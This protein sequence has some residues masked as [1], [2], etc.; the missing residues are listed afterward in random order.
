MS[1][2]YCPNLGIWLVNKLFGMW[3]C[4][5][6]GM[7]DQAGSD[8]SDYACANPTYGGSRLLGLIRPAGSGAGRLDQS[9]LRGHEPIA[10]GEEVVESLTATGINAD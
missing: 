7:W 4:A 3:D 5:C 6:T 10:R 1:N 8:M 2:R 9:E